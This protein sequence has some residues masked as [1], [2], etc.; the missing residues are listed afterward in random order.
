MILI[1][2]LLFAVSMG[3][4]EAAVVVYLRE[5]YYPLGF[6]F[7]LKDI[8]SLVLLTEIGREAASLLMIAVTAWSA[9]RTF[10]RRIAY[11]LIIF[12]VW[13]LVYY[14][15]L[16]LIFDWPKSLMDWDILFLIPV[17]WVA[18]VLAPVLSALGLTVMGLILNRLD[19]R[20]Y[21]VDL[22]PRDF[23]AAA[24]AA[25]PVLASFFAS[26]RTVVDGNFPERYPWALFFSGF[27]FSWIYFIA[28][29]R[30]WTRSF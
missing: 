8:D 25:A 17:P 16:A 24:V 30:T 2:I 20:G 26:T 29:I 9:G 1:L 28:R 3:I 19:T 5:L 18:P 27:I 4:F 23:L 10:I 14:G 21:L 13:D 12:G 22:T 6:S 15:M 11:V 7:P